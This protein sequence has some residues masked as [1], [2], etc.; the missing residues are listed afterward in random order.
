[1][2][3]GHGHQ[4][5]LAQVVWEPL[6]V[7]NLLIE[8]KLDRNG[9]EKA[10]RF[11]EHER[12]FVTANDPIGFGNFVVY[13]K[14]GRGLREWY[15]P[16]GWVKD[17]SDNQC[18]IKN[19]KTNIRIVPCNF[20]EFAG[21][22]NVRP[23]NKAPK[24]EVSRKKSACNMAAWLPNL[25]VIEPELNDG[26][27]T[28]VLGIHVDDRRSTGAELSF[29]TAFKGQHFTRFGK[30][31]ILLSGDD[32]DVAVRKGRGSGDDAIGIVDISVKRK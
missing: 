16:K 2:K 14:A 5:M 12:S 29:P 3:M 4:I 24:G 25:P 27:Q 17:D 8:M 26:F 13:A 15:L 1:M 31:I 23:T 19:P 21:N 22:R 28:W 6:E 20:D 18:A 7:D 32:N 11:A 9:L 10:I 30:R